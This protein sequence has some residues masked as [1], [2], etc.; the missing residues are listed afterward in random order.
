M[1]ALIFSLKSS[2]RTKRGLRK[3]GKSK[4]NRPLPIV[5]MGLFIDRDGIPL[6][7]CIDPGNTN[8]Q[9]TLKP[10]EQRIISEY[11]MSKFIVCTDAGLCV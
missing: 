3:F 5:E 6:G 10:I 1:I 8:E 7:V 9:K 4:E 11:G 2:S